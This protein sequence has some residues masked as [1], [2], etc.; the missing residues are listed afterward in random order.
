M[1]K[2]SSKAKNKK[3]PKNVTL[4]ELA[5]MMANGFTEVGGEFR[6]VY[7]RI[8]DLDERLSG[9]IKILDQKIS[10]VNTNVLGL[11][12]DYRKVV[13]RIENLELNAFGSVQ[14]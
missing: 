12:Y 11:Q 6:K 10:T 2:R 5:G 7:D 14:Q 13:A 1:K 9:Q 3:A 4:D 8:D